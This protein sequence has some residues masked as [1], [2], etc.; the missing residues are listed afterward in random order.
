MRTPSEKRIAILEAYERGGMSAAR[1]A[2]HHGIKY[3]TLCSWIGAARRQ[4]VAHH[5][6]QQ[7]TSANPSATDLPMR[8][9]EAVVHCPTPHEATGVPA[10]SVEWRGARLRIE[11]PAQARLAALL[12]RE[13]EV[14]PC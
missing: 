5:S 14:A 3:S 10:L 11:T 2:R 7:P 6:R 8:W 12:L 1:F 13:L 4:S 9:L